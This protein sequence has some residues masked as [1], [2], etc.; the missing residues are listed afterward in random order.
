MSKKYELLGP[1]RDA[2]D[3]I[4]S[5]R[6]RPQHKPTAQIKT[7]KM[8]ESHRLDRVIEAAGRISIGEICKKTGY[9]LGR[10]LAHV[11]YLID[12]GYAHL[13]GRANLEQMNLPPPKGAGG[14]G[15]ATSDAGTSVSDAPPPIAPEAADLQSPSPERVPTTH[16]RIIRDT[17]LAR[18]VKVLHGYKCQICGHTIKLPDGSFYAEAHHIQPLGEPDNGPDVIG[19]I[20][21]VCPNHHAELDLRARQI[22]VSELAVVPGH[23]VERRFVDY[24]NQKICT[25]AKQPLQH[26]AFS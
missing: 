7:K 25:V 6:P 3:I 14:A 10:V 20:L 21:C 5:I 18:R 19:N 16:N 23:A 1:A 8:Q 4:Q 15:N 12:K 22:T 13:Y 17:V 9:S 2:N 24:H 26:L 11:N